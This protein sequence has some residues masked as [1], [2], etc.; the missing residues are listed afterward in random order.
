MVS[1]RNLYLQKFRHYFWR[2]KHFTNSTSLSFKKKNYVLI[3]LFILL[4]PD[5]A[6]WLSTGTIVDGSG[7]MRGCHDLGAP[8]VEWVEARDTAQ[9]PAV[10]RTPTE[11][12]PA[13][14]LP[15]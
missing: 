2:E 9:C 5:I 8:G 14:G 11:N 4:K 7:A 1:C 15:L 3:K 13:Q 10:P 6:Q 12:N